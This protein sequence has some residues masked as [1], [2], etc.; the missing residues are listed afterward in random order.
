MVAAFVFPLKMIMLLLQ[1]LPCELSGTTPQVLPL[2]ACGWL[3]CLRGTTVPG[4]IGFVLH[5]P[6]EYMPHLTEPCS[7]CVFNDEFIDT[8][9][10]D[11]RLNSVCCS[12]LQGFACHAKS[13]SPRAAI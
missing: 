2:P 12:K 10:I 1:N 5:D 13:A 11:G 3:L 9:L 7:S 4:S 6:H 8:R